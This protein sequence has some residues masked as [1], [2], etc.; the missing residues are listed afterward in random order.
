MFL[1]FQLAITHM[2]SNTLRAKQP[3]A[4]KAASFAAGTTAWIANAGLM[5]T[6]YAAILLAMYK[7]ISGDDEPLEE[8]QNMQQS[9]DKWTRAIGL[10][11]DGGMPA[12]M[13]YDMRRS[14]GAGDINPLDPSRLVP[15]RTSEMLSESYQEV[16]R[17][18]YNRAAMKFPIGIQPLGRAYFR[19]KEAEEFGIPYGAGEVGPLSDYTESEQRKYKAGLTPW[20]MGKNIEAKRADAEHR[21]KRSDTMDLLADKYA[22]AYKRGDADVMIEV[23]NQLSAYNGKVKLAYMINTDQFIE[24]VENRILGSQDMSPMDAYRKQEMERSVGARP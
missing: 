7:L 2:M 23:S 24:A 9:D 19:G 8:V 22:R 10:L 3:V 11:L 12:L 15:T 17:G 16:R 6:P 18:E 14:L 4:R 13:G 1:P 21:A 5:G 20:S